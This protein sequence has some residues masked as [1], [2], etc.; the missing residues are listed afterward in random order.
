[1]ALG[2]PARQILEQLGHDALGAYIC[3]RA[4]LRMQAPLLA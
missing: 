2:E 4:A 3:R 1:M